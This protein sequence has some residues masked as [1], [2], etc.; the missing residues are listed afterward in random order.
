VVSVSAP[1]ASSFAQL[2]G[3]LKALITAEA[4]WPSPETGF[5]AHVFARIGRD[6]P[7]EVDAALR[8]ALASAESIPATRMTEAPVL[9]AEGF[10]LTLDPIESRRRR[11]AD[12]AL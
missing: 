3:Q 1:L 4:T 2:R 7:V 5:A 11:W 9:A 10:A 12:S 8:T 6:P